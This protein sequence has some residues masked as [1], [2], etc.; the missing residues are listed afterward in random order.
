MLLKGGDSEQARVDDERDLH[1]LTGC[2]A[3]R[4]AQR[5]ENLLAQLKKTL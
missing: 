4:D 1:I 5:V 2:G 3:K